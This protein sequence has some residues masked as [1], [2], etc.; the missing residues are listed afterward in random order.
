MVDRARLDFSKY[1][2]Y[3]DPRIKAQARCN[4]REP[5]D[6]DFKPGNWDVICTGGKE[7]SD[8]S[9]FYVLAFHH[10]TS[11]GFFY[12]SYLNFFFVSV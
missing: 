1:F 12:V 9:K 5:L 10:R 2:S 6:D 8:H 7:S 11:S 3:V 4:V